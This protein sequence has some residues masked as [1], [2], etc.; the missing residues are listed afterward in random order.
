MLKIQSLELSNYAGFDKRSVFDFI[1]HDGSYK[2]ICMFFGPNGCGKSTSL[3]AIAVLSRAKAYSKRNKEEDNLLLRKM[4]FHPDY[5]PNYA[6]FTK[7]NSCMEMI[8]IFED[9]I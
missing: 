4:Q 2:P 8:A 3:N 1:Y 6:G 7:Y 9:E 5:D